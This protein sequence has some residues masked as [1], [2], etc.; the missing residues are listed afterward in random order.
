MIQF[1]IAA[2]LL[3]AGWFLF[4]MLLTNLFKENY[5]KSGK[6][7]YI[8]IYI[9]IYIYTHVQKREK[10]RKEYLARQSYVRKN[11]YFK[12]SSETNLFLV[13]SSVVI[14]LFFT[15]LKFE[16]TWFLDKRFKRRIHWGLT[17]TVFWY[18]PHDWSEFDL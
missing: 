13:I 7:I 8:H 3:S 16:T 18:N 15:I 4:L 12:N 2:E 5:A 9:Y 17:E 10:N 1:L 11:S 14:W 6:Y